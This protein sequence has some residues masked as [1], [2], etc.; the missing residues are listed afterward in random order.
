MRIAALSAIALLATT[1]HADSIDIKVENFTAKDGIAEAVLK[2]TNSTPA[3]VSNVFIDCGFNDRD[4][5]TL[6]VGKALIKSI[7]AGAFAY[8]KVSV[9]TNQKVKIINCYVAKYR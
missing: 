1:A 8:A 4:L 3:R 2:V 5:K 9:V 7:E 6:D